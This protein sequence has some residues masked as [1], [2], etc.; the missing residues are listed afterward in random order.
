[1]LILGLS[2]LLLAVSAPAVLA[3]SSSPQPSPSTG[4]AVQ[5]TS[6]PIL[7]PSSEVPL[8]AAVQPKGRPDASTT[9]HGVR[10]ELWLS[11]STV[12]PGE[13][14]Q[15]VVRTTNLRE[16]PAYAMSGDCG[17]SDTSVDV[18]LDPEVP[19]GQTFSGNAGA[20]KR[21][22]LRDSLLTHAYLD[23]RKDVL[24]WATDSA[25]GGPALAYVECP[26][27]PP[28][29][30]R[31]GPGASVIERFAW[32]PVGSFEDDPWLQPMWPGA[33][34]VTVS[35]PYLSRGAPPALNVRQMY[36]MVRPI[37][38]TTAIEVASE[39]PNARGLPEFV[40]IALADPRFRAWVEEDATRRSWRGTSA[41]AESGPTF[42][43]S[44]YLWNLH[45]PP[46][47]G[48]VFLGL[49]RAID[50]QSHRGIV[51]LDPWTGE[52]LQVECVGQSQFRPCPQPG[53][54]AWSDDELAAAA[55]ENGPEAGL[56]PALVGAAS[57]AT[58]DWRKIARSPFGAHLPA[59]GWTG[60]ELVV[61]DVRSGRTASYDLATDSWTEHDRAP[62]R[63]DPF[64]AWVWTGSELLVL[65]DRLVADP[66]AFDP[67]TGSWRTLSPMPSDI[68]FDPEHAAWTGEMVVVAGGSPPQA[69]AYHPVDDTWERLPRL[70]SGTY[71]IG[72]TWTG[73]HVLA[74]TQLFDGQSIDVAQLEPGSQAWVPGA[75]G[76]VKPGVGPGLWMG[77]ALVYLRGDEEVAGP[78]SN[79]AYYPDDD[80]WRPLERACDVDTIRGL[81]AKRLIVDHSARR[82][83][84]VDTGE[85][86]RYRN[87][88]HRLYGGGAR[89]WTGSEVI[90]WSGIASLI[91]P[92]ERK[93]L[94]LRVAAEVRSE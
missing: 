86:H 9:R 31:L 44:L 65:P 76:P 93:G 22:V 47:T 36:R 43:P 14:V 37:R 60:E 83:M 16:T 57:L 1:V 39:G 69:A 90:Y 64:V 11:S 15:A 77:D 5:P 30:R 49:E 50:G 59:Y 82:A 88:P 3:Q 33:G 20:F 56:L 28:G 54:L 52:V 10:V 34:T 21:Q 4:L 81:A 13:W 68:Y 27:P 40:D 38:A 66:A 2:L 17:R 41:F 12:T 72:L 75:P 19:P 25:T 70:P 32:Y 71:V 61:V 89:V 78:E 58:D 53:P 35:W 26:Y 18:R 84:D 94:A 51:T 92:P 67:A 91:D 55:D 42:E 48:V 8:P 73:S 85:C 46:S 24:R 7:P 23:G 45:D 74:E 63:Y 87:P 6:G 80:E 62:D 29:P 79:A